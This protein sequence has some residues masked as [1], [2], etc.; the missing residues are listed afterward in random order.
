MPI[1]VI[2]SIIA[3]VGVLIAT[4]ISYITSQRQTK[5]EF[6]KLQADVERAYGTKLFD[7]KLDAYPELY[8]YVSDFIKILNS[9]RID[10][11][12]VKSFYEHWQK[13]DS[14]YAILFSAS[15]HGICSRVRHKIGDLA[16]KSD[17]E[18]L[19]FFDPQSIKNLKAELQAVELALKFE[20][21]VFALESPDIEKINRHYTYKAAHASADLDELL[22][23]FEKESKT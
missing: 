8:A 6:Q 23:L 11:K 7:K 20:L 14:K 18:M 16:K 4:I 13:W 5:A 15:T 19:Q 17:E 10:S 3:V 1:E 2:S 9:R 22:E 12:L 21:G